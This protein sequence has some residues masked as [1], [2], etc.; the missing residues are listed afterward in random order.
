MSSYF[1][2]NTSGMECNRKDVRNL[3]EIFL[4]A[5][6][7]VNEILTLSNGVVRHV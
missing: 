7:V 5:Q 6:V 2:S 1:N 3:I 4:L